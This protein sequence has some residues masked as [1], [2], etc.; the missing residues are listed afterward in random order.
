MFAPV[1]LGPFYV[2]H[3]TRSIL[4]CS[5]KLARLPAY[6][7]LPSSL[8]LLCRAS[9]ALRSYFLLSCALAR[10]NRCPVA[11]AKRSQH[12]FHCERAKDESHYTDEDGRSLPTD[13]PQNRIRK[14]QQKIGQEEHHQ[15]N[16]ASFEPLRH[17]INI[18]IGQ[19]DHRHHCSSPGDGRHRQRKHREIA[20]F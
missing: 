2:A 9:R 20:P 17:R 19:D 16:N 15:K 5:L 8:Y 1:R 13:H 3:P 6:S 7:L 14:K 18:V 4:P 10:R 12:D 11:D